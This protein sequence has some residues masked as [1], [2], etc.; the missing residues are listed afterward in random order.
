[1][2][3]RHVVKEKA[4]LVIFRHK[5]AGSAGLCAPNDELEHLARSAGAAIAGRVV[6]EWRG[7]DP[8]FFITQ[9]RREALKRQVL[10]DGADFVIFDAELTP[11]QQRNL[12]DFLEMKVIDRTAL[13]LDIFAQRARSREGKLQIELAQLDYLMPR[14]K[15]RGMQMS[16]LGGGIGTRGPGE[17]QL[18]ADRRKVKE[19]MQRIGRDLDHVETTRMVQR[20][21]RIRQGVQCAALIGYTNA[22]KSSLLNLLAGACVTAENR[23][24]S[25]L[26]PTIRKVSLGGGGAMLLSDTVGF[27]RGLPHQ[28]VA[29]FKAT[30]EEVREAHLLLHVIDCTSPCAEQQAAAVDRVL[31]E[32]G[33][34]DRETIFVLNKIDAVEDPGI[35]R[36]LARRFEPVAAVSAMTGQG[37]DKLRSLLDRWL[38]QRVR[39]MYFRLPAT[40]KSAIE[41]I[42]KSGAVLSS[43]CDKDDVL[44]EARIDQN[45]AHNLSRFAVP[46]FY[47]DKH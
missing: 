19:R 31:E 4:L 33:V 37:I 5:D 24:F 32:I 22:G 34:N 13:I 29:A 10:Q 47:T 46:A 6:H 9:G 35:V 11:A 20:Q 14:L 17:T 38:S 7:C 27:I 43:I 45:I 2:N 23:L 44:I 42:M 15:G 36:Q 39:H 1:M 16:R 40:E 21:N 8:A 30:L 28:L 25:T 18:E 26:D 41:R 12:E 3:Y